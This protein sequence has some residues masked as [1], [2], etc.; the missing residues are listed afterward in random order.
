[1][2]RGNL[3]EHGVRS[4]T[5]TAETVRRHTEYVIEHGM[6]RPDRQW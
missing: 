6:E 4:V 1:M 2:V 3:I 5:G